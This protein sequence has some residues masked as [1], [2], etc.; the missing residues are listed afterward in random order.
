MPHWDPTLPQTVE[1]LQPREEG[2]DGGGASCGEGTSSITR[3]ETPQPTSK[4]SFPHS[5]RGN[6]EASGSRV[7]RQSLEKEKAARPCGSQEQERL[8]DRAS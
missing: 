1:D 4:P 5:R 2:A 8:E 3:Q 7:L 6:T